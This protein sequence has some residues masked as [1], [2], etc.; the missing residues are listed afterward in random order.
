M[1]DR[2]AAGRKTDAELTD[3][4]KLSLD[5]TMEGL[6]IALARSDDEH[7]DPG[8]KYD[9]YGRLRDREIGHAGKLGSISAQLVSALVKLRKDENREK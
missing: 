6:R 9:G 1:E 4:L 3:D 8:K 5:K 2:N 7:T